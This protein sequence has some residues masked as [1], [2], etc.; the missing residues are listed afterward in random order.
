MAYT[1]K[2]KSMQVGV[3]EDVVSFLRQHGTDDM[4]RE[5]N[6][7]E[8]LEKFEENTLQMV[9][10]V[11]REV[12]I[13]DTH[14]PKKPRTPY[15]FFDQEFRAQNPGLAHDQIV[16]LRKT[17]WETL[18]K[19]DDLLSKYARLALEDKER[20][21]REIR[22]YV[23]GADSEE[24]TG[25]KPRDPNH[26]RPVTTSFFYFMTEYRP[27][28]V[29]LGLKGAEI[30]KEFSRI[31]K[32]LG[33]QEKERFTDLQTQDSA[34]YR[35]EMENYITP[36]E[37]MSKKQKKTKKTKDHDAPTVLTPY[38][39]FM[40]DVRPKLTSQGLKGKDL[41]VAAGHQWNTL[42]QTQPAEFQ[43][44]HQLYEAD[45]T[46]LHQYKRIT[47]EARGD[48]KMEEEIPKTQKALVARTVEDLTRF[49]QRLSLTVDKDT[50]ATVLAKMIH[51][52]QKKK[53]PIA[54]AK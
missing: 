12:P 48:V 49:A 8:N 29:A 28:V 51:T 35:R 31:W 11:L 32:A 34:R 25:K 18:R 30:N 7:P 2:L 43:R 54:V 47:T 9:A 53:K 15:T 33:P 42:K 41:S 24:S 40:K 46:A 38:F 36:P 39:H 20:Y 44:Y 52:A 45:K 13:N 16:A 22:Q 19:D 3:S 26:P 10:D 17:R 23:P 21:E 37:C 4:V 27:R 1:Q 6:T 5:W 50:N 14:A